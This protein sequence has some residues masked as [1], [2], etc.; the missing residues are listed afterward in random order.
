VSSTNAVS[1]ATPRECLEDRYQPPLPPSPPEQEWVD[2]E[3]ALLVLRVK[4]SRWWTQLQV[5]VYVYQSRTILVE[6]QPVRAMVD[7][8]LSAFF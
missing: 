4:L 7:T 2:D 3:F 5:H 8:G 6:R 1:Q